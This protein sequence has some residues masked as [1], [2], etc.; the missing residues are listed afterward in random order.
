LERLF[1]SWI[2]HRAERPRPTQL[3]YSTSLQGEQSHIAITAPSVTPSVQAASVSDAT[4]MDV[5]CRAL[6]DLKRQARPSN[7]FTNDVTCRTLFA[8]SPRAVSAIELSAGA[9]QRCAGNYIG[10]AFQ[11]VVTRKDF[12]NHRVSPGQRRAPSQSPGIVTGLLFF[13]RTRS[14]REAPT[15]RRSVSHG[16]DYDPLPEDRAGNLH[17]QIR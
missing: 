17:R 12:K 16:H 14:L 15:R 13:L 4:G 5:V 1:C 11:K 7:R 3:W 6:G 2:R 9:S 8:P 10:S